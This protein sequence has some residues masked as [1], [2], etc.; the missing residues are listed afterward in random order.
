MSQVKCYLC[1]KA[2]QQDKAVIDQDTYVTYCSLSCMQKDTPGCVSMPSNAI[3][4]TAIDVDMLTKQQEEIMSTKIG[5]MAK[6]YKSN[7]TK[8]ITELPEV[9]TELEVFDDQFETTDKETKEHKVI[10]QKVIT[11]NG[12]SYRVPAS[13]FQQLKI[14]LEDN[15]TLKKFKV[16]KSGTMMETRYQVIPLM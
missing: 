7:A 1:G 12:E 13:V 9:S 6:D 14:V 3:K 8:N 15:P 5:E 4:E 2:V 10:K 16:K 11:V